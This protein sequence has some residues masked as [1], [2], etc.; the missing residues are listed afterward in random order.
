MLYSLFIVYYYKE[1]TKEKESYV[2][3]DFFSA[4]T[5]T[6][7]SYIWMQYQPDKIT[8]GK[9]LLEEAVQEG[10]VEAYCFLARTYLPGT[11]LWRS[12]GLCEDSNMAADL[13][14][15]GAENGSLCLILTMLQYEALAQE[16]EQRISEEAQKNAYET[17]YQF[18]QGGHAFCQMLIG[19]CYYWGGYSRIFKDNDLSD[20]DL[21]QFAAEWF[22]KAV[23]GGVTAALINLYSIYEESSLPDYDEGKIMELMEYSAEKGDPMWQDSY[24]DRKS[25]RLNSS[26]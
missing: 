7:I 9:Q 20:D 6:A 26:H 17:V 24:A 21:E 23:L 19:M 15:E 14:L 22:E 12:A 8:Q 10:D 2:M 1:E 16:V 11:L 3:N 4:K 18:A 25:T 5:Q 13:L